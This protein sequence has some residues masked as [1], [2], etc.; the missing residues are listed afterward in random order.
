[1]SAVKADWWRSACRALEASGVKHGSVRLLGLPLGREKRL[2]RA[3]LHRKTVLE[4]KNSV[5]DHLFHTQAPL[6]QLDI[7]NLAGAEEALKDP[8]KRRLLLTFGVNREMLDS[9]LA[10]KYGAETGAALDEALS[11]LLAE[12]ILLRVP[13]QLA[14]TSSDLYLAAH[15]HGRRHY[16]LSEF[17]RLLREGRDYRGELESRQRR[18]ASTNRGRSYRL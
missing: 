5:S 2:R 3:L 10:Q 1:M 6:A 18:E 4:A 7:R 11:E 12:G 15:G 9:E 13:G 14:A 17:N 8:A 16:D